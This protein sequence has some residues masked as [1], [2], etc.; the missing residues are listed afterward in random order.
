MMDKNLHSLEQHL[1]SWTDD[2]PT[3]KD[4][5]VGS[6]WN[7]V[8]IKD[9]RRAQMHDFEDRSFRFHREEY[10]LCLYGVFDGFHG[11]HVADYIT[12]R[13]PAEL[14]LGQIVPDIKDEQVK[15]LVKQVFVSIDR[16][17]FGSIGEQLAARMVMRSDIVCRQT[18]E[19]K[20]KLAEIEHFVSS[21]CSATIAVIVDKRIFVSNIGDCQAFLCYNNGNNEDGSDIL[22]SSVSIDHNI[23]NEDERLRL[24]HLGY[25]PQNNSNETGLGQQNYTR[26]FGNYLV[27][28]GYKECPQLSSCRDD[29]VVAEPEI[30]GPIPITDDLKM[31]VIATKSLCDTVQSITSREPQEEL[32]RLLLQHLASE[33]NSSLSSVAQS[34]VDHI[35][36]MVQEQQSSNTDSLIKREDMSL[37]VRCFKSS[38]GTSSQRRLSSPK[39][40][41]ENPELR[42]REEKTLTQS[43]TARQPRPT[44]SSTTTESSGVYIAHGR[45]LPVDEDGRIEPYVDFGPFYKLWNARFENGANDHELPNMNM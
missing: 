38:H 12:K 26:C 14:V 31:L 5:G 1:T 23:D 16:E 37:L 36:R 28:G 41:L 20:S 4:S 10:N 3:C 44:R 40:N 9:G 42:R 2:V 8:Y 35:V 30:Q 19:Q 45:E 43:S 11:S 33:P 32:S 21:G 39:Y 15:E 24:Q 34:T 29:P 6:S 13:L 18:Q 22:V 7:E 25:Q 27:K 17:Y